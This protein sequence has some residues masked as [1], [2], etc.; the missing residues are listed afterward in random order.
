MDKFINVKYRHIIDAE[1]SG[2]AETSTIN[3]T[4]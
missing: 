2:N 3:R 4:I 1:L